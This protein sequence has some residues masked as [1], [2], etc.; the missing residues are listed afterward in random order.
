MGPSP[1]KCL[2][3]NKSWKYRDKRDLESMLRG[4]KSNAVENIYPKKGNLARITN[5]VE[6]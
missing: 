2:V 3:G 6:W 4:G 1:L 5:V